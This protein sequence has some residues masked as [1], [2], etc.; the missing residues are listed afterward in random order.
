MA[1]AKARK[2]KVYQAPFGFHESVVAAPSQT[3]ALRAWGSHQNLFAEGLAK[4]TTEA[5][6]VEAALKHPETPLRRAIGSDDPFELEAASLPKVPCAEKTQPKEASSPPRK[7]KPAPPQADRSALDSAE[8][9]LRRLE[10]QRRREE[11]RF[12]RRWDELHREQEEARQKYTNTK[13]AAD[14]AVKAA[15]KDYRRAG[16]TD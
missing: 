12:S 14:Q 10:D 13:D 4:V 8:R 15:Q 2:L 6:A 11:D 1:L 9:E 16:G 5:A 7:S 3:A